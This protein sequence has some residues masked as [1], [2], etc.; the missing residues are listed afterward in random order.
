MSSKGRKDPFFIVGSQRSGSTLLRLMLNAHSEIA[1]PEEARFI[2]PII[3]KKVLNKN[4]LM[5]IKKYLLRHPQYK[6]WNY[7]FY[8]FVNSLDQKG[9]IKSGDLIESLYLSYA[10]S[11]GK[12]SWGD[13]SLFFD[14]IERIHKLIPNVK[15]IHI[16]RDGR[17][18]CL[19]WAKM[20]S[21]ESN[22]AISAFD[23]AF[24][25][26]RI[27]RSIK[28]LE[29]GAY[30]VLRYEDLIVDPMS[31]IKKVCLFLDIEFEDNMLLFYKNSEKY[32]GD[33][34]SDL[35]FKPINHENIKK[36]MKSMSD[37][38]AKVYSFIAQELLKE[39]GYF[40]E[41][42]NFFIKI[43]AILSFILG[44]PYKL[45]KYIFNRFLV[46]ILYRGGRHVSQ[47]TFD[48]ISVGN[49]PR[50]KG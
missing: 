48:V 26:N 1:V 16:V 14:E 20:D 13:K 15:F 5:R 39:Y 33:H 4:E 23:W 42:V 22:V 31:T 18:V 19:S 8:D 21:K 3:H 43:K 11:E 49:M 41:K 47:N 10:K 50:Y 37:D 12:N 36:W 29:N 46:K 27:K 30:M 17:D 45:Y 35:I 6:L 7:D 28:K 44:V 9:T 40:V 32:I 2:R 34:H 25:N 24:K 38:D